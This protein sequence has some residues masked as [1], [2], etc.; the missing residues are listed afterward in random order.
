MF[1][2]K[3]CVSY[4]MKIFF[5]EVLF[6]LLFY[7][8]HLGLLPLGIYIYVWFG[9]L[10]PSYEY[11]ADPVLSISQDCAVCCFCCKS[12]IRYIRD[13]HF[14]IVDL[15]VYLDANSILSNYCNVLMSLEF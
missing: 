8:L 6:I 14:C 11:P 1:C 4:V 5:Y 15:F 12:G 3:K 9:L 7:L 2:L 10:F 13:C